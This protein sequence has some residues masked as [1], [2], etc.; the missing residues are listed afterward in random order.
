MQALTSKTEELEFRINR[1]TVDGTNRIGDLEFRICEMEEGCDIGVLGDTP[2]LGGVDN[3]AGVPDPVVS[4]PAPIGN[5]AVNEQADF[6]RAQAALQAGDF[7]A[8]ADQF[9]AFGT[10]YQGSPLSA[11]ALFGKVD[12]FA[13][14][15]HPGKLLHD[16]HPPTHDAVQQRG[17]ADVR[18]AHDGYRR[19][20][21]GLTS[22]LQ[23]SLRLLAHDAGLCPWV[24]QMTVF[25]G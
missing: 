25:I 14:S 23:T 11:D 21:R 17:L 5:L 4:T 20:T 7:R 24:L 3:G 13:I 6:E 9:A 16:R 18:T 15:R 8:A 1:I 19:Q 2:T 10:T 22:R 12:I